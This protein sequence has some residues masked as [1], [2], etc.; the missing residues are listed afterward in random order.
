MPEERIHFVG[1]A[2]S[3]GAKMVLLSQ[4]QRHRAAQL[5][6][7]AEHV[8]LSLDPEFQFEFGMAMMFPGSEA[9]GDFTGILGD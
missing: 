3:L 9:D 8:D 6:A 2:A 1:N 7:S 5:A 4:G